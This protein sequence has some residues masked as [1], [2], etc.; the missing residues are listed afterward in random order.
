MSSHINTDLNLELERLRFL[1][2]KLAPAEKS[3]FELTNPGLV[4]SSSPSSLF[5]LHQPSSKAKIQSR[6]SFE[7]LRPV[8]GSG[9]AN[10]NCL[11][12]VIWDI[13]LGIP[14]SLFIAVTNKAFVQWLGY[15]KIMRCPSSSKSFPERSFTRAR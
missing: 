7:R 10:A 14:F 4:L 5:S 15:E 2:P 12:L 9:G 11:G 1:L 8:R 6:K 13:L 3:F